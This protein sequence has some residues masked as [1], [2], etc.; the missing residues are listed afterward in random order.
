[1]SDIRISELI[2]SLDQQWIQVGDL[3]VTVADPYDGRKC[4]VLVE[5]ETD[6]DGRPT[7]ICLRPGPIT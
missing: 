4:P 7:S 5:V 2:A 6:D 3:L 1:M